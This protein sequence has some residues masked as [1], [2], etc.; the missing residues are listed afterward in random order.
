MTANKNCKPVRTWFNACHNKSAVQTQSENVLYLWDILWLHYM[1]L[2]HTY[3]E[4][5]VPRTLELAE[6]VLLPEELLSMSFCHFAG[7]LV[8]QE[9]ARWIISQCSRAVDYQEKQN[10]QKDVVLAGESVYFSKILY[11]ISVYRFWEIIVF[12]KSSTFI[13]FCMSI[14]SKP[15]HSE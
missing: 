4:S 8:I 2:Y 3:S 1:V 11:N 7:F 6:H 5:V 13:V 12:Q 9:A 14:Y 10:L 15:S